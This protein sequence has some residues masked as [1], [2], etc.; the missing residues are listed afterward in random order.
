MR[1]LT[2]VASVYNKTI[3]NPNKLTEFGCNCRSKQSNIFTEQMR[4]I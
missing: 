4:H 2:S 1:N 3:A